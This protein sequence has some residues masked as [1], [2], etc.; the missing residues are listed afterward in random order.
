MR[1]RLRRT[2]ARPGGEET[3]AAGT[4]LG[5]ANAGEFTAVMVAQVAAQ[6]PGAGAEAAGQA[7]GSADFGRMFHGN[8]LL[9]WIAGFAC[10]R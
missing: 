2:L 1:D 8:V 7:E 10:R 6:L 3:Q 5:F 9:V 4:L